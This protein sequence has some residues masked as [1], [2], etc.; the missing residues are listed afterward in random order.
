MIDKEI[1]Y[2]QTLNDMATTINILKDILIEK[3][4]S[5]IDLKRIDYCKKVIRQVNEKVLII[6][7]I[8]KEC[9]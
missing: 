4:L 5:D 3:E 7:E 8:N 1:L 9:I 6:N 2:Y